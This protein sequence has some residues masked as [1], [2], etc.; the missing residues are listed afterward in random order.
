MIFLKMQLTR[1][2]LFYLILSSIL[3]LMFSCDKEEEGT[4]QQHEGFFVDG[5]YL[6]DKTGDTVILRGANTMILYW[7]KHGKQ[8]YPELAKTG[9]NT[10]RIFWQ[11]DSSAS[12]P[13][14]LDQTIQNCIDNNMIPIPCVWDATGKWN[15][16]EQCVDYWTRPGIVDVLNK[17]REYILLNIANEP[18]DHAM[19]RDTF[20]SRYAEI[21]KRMRNAGLHMPLI[22]DS[23]RWGRNA[24]SVINNGQYLLEQDPDNN[25]IFSWHLWD[26]HDRG[27]GPKDS[28]KKVIDQSIE[29]N[30]CMIVGEFGPCDALCDNCK[31][32][33]INWE[34]LIEYC[35]EKRIGWLAWV[36]RWKDCHAIV[37]DDYGDWANEGW[38][39]PLVKT[40][41]YGLEKTAER[42]RYIKNLNE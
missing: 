13:E 41:P 1:N 30:I 11:T 7:D 15:K 10:C 27:L 19:G 23:D 3:A 39:K 37:S 42:P 6:R 8:N 34:Y 28:I 33:P 16:L 26:P 4:K 22:I 14:D 2:I 20:R 17:H 29:K 35:Q 38:S 9:A 21:V 5:R 31:D 12:T 40:H 25:L 18:G 32:K 24:H 36:W